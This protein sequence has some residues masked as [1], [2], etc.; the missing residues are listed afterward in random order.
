MIVDT[1]ALAAILLKEPD[2]EGF[3]AAISDRRDH[4]SISAGSVIELMTVVARRKGPH[5]LDEV[6]ALLAALG[7]AVAAVD[8]VQV[9]FAR[10][11]IARYGKGTGAGKNGLNFG[12]CF[13]YALAKA[14]GR[15]LLFKGNDFSQTD[16]AIA[17]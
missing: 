4:A 9:E 12:D 10:E 7:L 17:V 2:A 5:A 1:S 14:T 11:A 3:M 8:G 6:D 16:V 13:A 15:P